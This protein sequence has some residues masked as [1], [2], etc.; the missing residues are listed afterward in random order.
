M[1]LVLIALYV[2]VVCWFGYAVLRVAG[3]ADARMDKIGS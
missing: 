3:G 1:T 2:V